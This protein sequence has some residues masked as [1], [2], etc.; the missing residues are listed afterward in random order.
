MGD[1]RL[2]S[3]A[4]PPGGSC[5][6]MDLKIPHPSVQADQAL[7]LSA[8]ALTPDQDS[9]TRT[10]TTHLVHH[11][12]FALPPFR[13][14]RPRPHPHRSK[15]TTRRDFGPFSCRSDRQLST[16]RLARWQS[17]FPICPRALALALARQLHPL[18]GSHSSRA[19]RC[20]APRRATASE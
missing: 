20:R 11:L 13:A 14:R 10:S 18:Y 19:S 4:A 12:H 7:R 16:F 1:R 3:A 2:Q 5:W 15:M 9:R 8:R 6:P 17:T